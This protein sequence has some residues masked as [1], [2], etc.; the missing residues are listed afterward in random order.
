M[1]SLSTHGFGLGRDFQAL[2]TFGKKKPKAAFRFVS[3]YPEACPS[4][5]LHFSPF[6]D[7][8][9]SGDNAACCST[10]PAC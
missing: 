4:G 10:L 7:L 2:L 8:N 6:V 5:D 1:K 3:H 9:E